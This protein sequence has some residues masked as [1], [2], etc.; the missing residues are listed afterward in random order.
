[1]MRQGIDENV[2][3]GL[4]M[5]G[6]I[7][8]HAATAL[9]AAKMNPVGGLI[10]GSAEARAFNQG[11][12]QQRP[13]AVQSFP[14]I[15]QTMSG[16]RKDFAC[17][18]TNRNIR[19][20]KEATIGNNELK[21]PFLFFSTPSDP[22]VSRRHFQCRTG[23]LKAG[24]IPARQFVGFDEIA[25]MSAERDFV[26]KIMPASNE[27]FEDRSKLPISS[28]NKFQGQ[29]LK[30]ACAA[31]NRRFIFDECGGVCLARPR[32]TTGSKFRNGDDA[33]GV[34]TFKQNTAFFVFEFSVR[35]FPVE[36]F[37]KSFGQFGEAEIRKSFDGL[38]NEVDLIGGKGTTG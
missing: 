14:I 10:T 2:L 37:R 5:S 9:C 29:R 3:D 16:K 32:G 6:M 28:L 22:G 33:V 38:T 19:R 12:K 30:L 23:K 27:L 7:P 34:K 17:Q 4:A 36:Q 24:E 20:N 31:G 21:I 26:A 13:V 35:P 11:F 1:M 18:S 8:I 25:Q 15:R